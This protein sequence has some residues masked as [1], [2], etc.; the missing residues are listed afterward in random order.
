LQAFFHANNHARTSGRFVGDLSA[1]K[2]AC[3]FARFET[4]KHTG[5]RHMFLPGFDTV[6]HREMT[7]GIT[8]I[9]DSFYREMTHASTGR[10]D[11]IYRDMGQFLEDNPLSILGISDYNY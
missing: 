9:R 10:R 5:K 6:A 8:G 4:S 3:M 7:Q 1:N 2:L 11:R